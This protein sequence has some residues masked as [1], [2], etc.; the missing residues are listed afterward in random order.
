M[1]NFCVEPLISRHDRD[2]QHFRLR[3]LDQQEHG[4]LVGASGSAR[5]LVDDDLAL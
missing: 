4:L 3:R 1:R 5:V 2:A